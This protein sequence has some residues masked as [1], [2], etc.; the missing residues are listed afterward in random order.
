MSLMKRH[1]EKLVEEGTACPT[2]FSIEKHDYD[3]CAKQAYEDATYD[4]RDDYLER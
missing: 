4:M 1:L 2:C 3:E